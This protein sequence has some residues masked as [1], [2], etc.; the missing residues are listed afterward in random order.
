MLLTR[1]K[2]L[3]WT[4]EHIR[5]LFSCIKQQK[6]LSR[7]CLSSFALLDIAYVNTEI[8]YCAALIAFINNMPIA[9]YLWFLSLLRLLYYLLYPALL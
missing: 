8:I 5:Q 3:Q 1:K 6:S 4:K 9:H 7:M 2:P